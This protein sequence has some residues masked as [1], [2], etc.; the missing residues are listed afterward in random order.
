[1]SAAAHVCVR[2][3]ARTPVSALWSHTVE[4]NCRGKCPLDS[5]RFH[6]TFR[7]G[8]SV[9]AEKAAGVFQGWSRC[10]RLRGVLH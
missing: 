8:F 7:A 5:L 3:S 9:S 6:V 10:F 1:M 2:G 4:C